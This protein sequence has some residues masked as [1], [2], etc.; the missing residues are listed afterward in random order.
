MY[1]CPGCGSQMTFDIMGQQLKCGRCDRTMSIEEADTREARQA[2]STFAVDLLT[3]PTCGA[4]IRAMNTAQASFCSY[5]GA[6]VMLERRDAEIEP[7]ERIAPFRISREQCFEKYKKLIGK[8]F[9]ADHRLKR[10]IRPESFRGIY[11]PYHTYEAAVKGDVELEGTETKGD[12][13]YY[14]NTTVHLNHRYKGILHDASKEMPDELSERISR[15]DQTEFRPFSPA[16][17]SGFYADTADTDPEKY[18]PYAKAEAI[19]FGIQDTV[20]D[21]Q[22][23]LTYSPAQGQKKLLKIAEAEYTG[24]TLVPVWFM[25]MKSGNRVLYAVQNGVSGEM[26]ADR[27]LDIP[28]FGLLTAGLAVVLF[29]VFQ[30]FLTLRPEMAMVAAMMLAV[31]AQ[32]AVNNRRRAVYDREQRGGDNASADVLDTAKE[33]GKLEKKQKRKGSA[34]FT[35]AA[36][37]AGAAVAAAAVLKMMGEVGDS[38]IYK[39]AAVALTLAMAGVMFIGGKKRSRMPAGSWGALAAMVIG[40][41]LMVLDPF[42]SEDIAVYGVTALILA[43]VIWACV[44]LLK[45]YNRSCSNP[46]PQ[47]ESHQGGDDR[48]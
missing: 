5:C 2:G 1:S 45:I 29:F 26:W 35:G 7:P 9:C 28:R 34:A 24:D 33:R 13:T 4:E 3:C 32:V 19:R 22:D 39:I 6:S 37:A 42:H 21:L 47:F 31:G 38:R 16:Y 48:A 40:A 17:L 10:D 18:Y 41:I 11:V 44:D 12:T 8:S 14:Y 30:L 36:G 25:S 27:P 15:V 46:L 43:G 23:G 20:A